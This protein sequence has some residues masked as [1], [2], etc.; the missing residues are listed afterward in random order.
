MKFIRK[1]LSFILIFQCDVTSYGSQKYK[2]LPEKER[3][4]YKQEYKDGLEKYN[5]LKNDLIRLNPELKKITKEKK[6][7]EKDLTPFKLYYQECC[8]KTNIGKLEAQRQYK[9]LDDKQKLEYI[10][11][12]FDME[13]PM[14]KKYSKDERRIIKHSTGQLPRPP[15]AFNLYVKSVAPKVHNIDSRDRMKKASNQN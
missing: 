12:L 7:P 14:E 13:T 5:S 2:K 10:N 15:S 11:K 4:R 3:E 6:N 9:Y 8:A 1:F